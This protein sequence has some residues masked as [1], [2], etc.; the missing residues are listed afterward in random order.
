MTNECRP[1]S[2]GLQRRSDPDRIGIGDV[3]WGWIAK[4]NAE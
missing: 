2:R 1:T 3:D 4:R